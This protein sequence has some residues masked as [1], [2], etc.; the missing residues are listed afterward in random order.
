M[1]MTIKKKEKQSVDNAKSP[2]STR[3]DKNGIYVRGKQICN[4]STTP[5]RE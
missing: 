5:R 1:Y 3:I 4:A 2:K